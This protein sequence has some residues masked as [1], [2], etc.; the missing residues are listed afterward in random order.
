MAWC[1]LQSQHH[2]N[3]S[4][5]S[6]NIW[7]GQP[8]YWDVYSVQTIE[9]A[10]DKVGICRKWRHNALVGKAA[11]G[12]AGL[13]YF[14]GNSIEK[15]S[16]SRVRFKQ[17]GYKKELAC[18]LS[19]QRA[20]VMCEQ[21]YLRQTFCR[22]TTT[23]SGYVKA[24]YNSH[25]NLHIWGLCRTQASILCAGRGSLEHIL[26]S[27]LKPLLKITG[28]MTRYLKHCCDSRPSH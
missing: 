20:E 1:C 4:Q 27:C 25:A 21:G 17:V 26:R 3:L 7:S 18:G 13:G 19:Q 28:R 10:I 24:I 16:G 2:C 5:K 9:K 8:P 12:Q 23:K 6:C 15:H 11:T 14:P 22:Q